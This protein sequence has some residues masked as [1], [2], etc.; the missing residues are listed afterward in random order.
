MYG[1]C[2]C[3]G[4]RDKTV[5]REIEGGERMKISAVGERGG[6]LFLVVETRSWSSI[7][8]SGSIFFYLVKCYFGSNIFQTSII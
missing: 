6:L 3:G 4:G 1:G 8:G 7:S 5:N 2:C